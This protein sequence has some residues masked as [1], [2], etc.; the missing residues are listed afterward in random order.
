MTSCETFGA[1]VSVRH[2]SWTLKEILTIWFWLD[3]LVFARQQPTEKRAMYSEPSGP[4]CVPMTSPDCEADVAPRVVRQPVID[5]QHLV[6]VLAQ[7]DFLPETVVGATVVD[8]PRAVVVARERTRLRVGLVVAVDRAG[9]RLHAARAQVTEVG[10][11]LAAGRVGYF[12]Q[13]VAFSIGVG[14]V[15]RPS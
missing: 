6:V 9:D 14:S 10:R 15:S 8:Q 11:A 7:L 2:S 1:A 4:N 3:S 5:A 13:I 12:F